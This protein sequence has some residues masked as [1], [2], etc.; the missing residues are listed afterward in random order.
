LPN[1]AGLKLTTARYYTPSGHAIQ[2]D[3]IHPDVLLE[4]GTCGLPELARV[5]R[6]RD[7]PGHLAPEGPQRDAGAPPAPGPS[8]S[9][10]AGS[11][12]DG[13]GSLSRDVPVDPSASPDVVLRV[14]YQT[15]RSQ[16]RAAGS[17]SR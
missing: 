10:D 12:E 16:I 5:L 7:L 15:L 14:G 1:G 4:S 9:V 13:S 17:R 8:A 3:G 6:E 11:S 2:A